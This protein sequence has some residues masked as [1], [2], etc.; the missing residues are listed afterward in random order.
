MEKPE[1]EHLSNDE[2]SDGSRVVDKFPPEARAEAGVLVQVE[3][4]EG[5]SLRLANDGH[6]VLLPQPTDD[7]NEPLNWSSRKK[8]LILLVVAWA[9]L[10][11]DF[12]SAAGSA[13]VI[14]QAAEWHKSP[15]SVNYNNSIN[16]PMM[17]I[18]GL[19][20]VPMTS[21]LMYITSPYWGPLLANFV[22]GESHQWQDAFWLGVGVNGISLLLILSFLD[23]T[24]YNRDLPSPAQPA[25]GQGFFSRLVRLTGLW[26]MKHHSGYFEFVF[27]AYKR[28]LLILSKPVILLVLLAYF[29]CFAWAI[30]VNISTAILF[31]LPQEMGGY[32]YNF[33]QLGYLHFAPIVGVFLGEIFGHFF[34]DHLTRRYVRKHNG[35]FEP[36]ARLTTIYI[37]AIPM[38]AGLILMG[39][40]LHKHLSVAAIVIGWGMH[41][42]GI[43][44]ASVA[45]ASYLLDAYPSAPAEVCGLT[46]VFRALSGF[47]VGYYQQPWGAKVGYDVSFGTQACIVAASMILI[48]IVHRF[49]HQLRLKFGQVR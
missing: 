12:T 49:G 27:D 6:T 29:M 46:N 41:A 34:N 23:E 9:A 20:W 42:F 43:M 35:V 16:V 30:G 39:Q 38:I 18:G 26:Q 5:T 45:V 44:L 13:P 21:A 28:V 19:I 24:W 11:S 17:A 4:A 2:K 10:T 15:N 40:A 22:I 3:R 1:V 32:G 33:T 8:H 14:L 48:A 25:R 31:G 7:P 47:S 37:S 36:E